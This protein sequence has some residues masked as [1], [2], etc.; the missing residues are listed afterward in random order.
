MK[1]SIEIEI[2]DG[3]V[4]KISREG[5][6]ISIKFV[7]EDICERVKTLDDAIEIAEKL[8]PDI[9]N[10]W[11]N[12]NNCSY[13]EKLYTYRMIVAVLT[14]NEKNHLTKGNVYYP[15]V[16]FCEPNKVKNCAGDTV[17]GYIKAD[18]R[19]FAVVGGCALVGGGVGLGCFF[20]C[21]GVTDAWIAVGFRSVS[22]SRIA[23]HISKYFG[24]L[25]FDI[26]YGE[27]NC[28]YEWID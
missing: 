16:Q 5:D 17:V 28:D 19:K 25:V 1:K 8:Y 24:R 13:E 4:E 11:R 26:M 21:C 27:S 14:N 12:L 9:Y 2:P 23:N 22:S 6:T 7:D 20:S 15:F 18:G 10:K 3:K